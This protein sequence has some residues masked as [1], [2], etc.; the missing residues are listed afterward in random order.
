MFTTGVLCTVCGAHVYFWVNK[1]FNLLQFQMT[2]H[3]S[4]DL[5]GK[6]ET[7]LCEVLP[8]WGQVIPDDGQVLFKVRRDGCDIAALV[9]YRLYRWPGH[10][11][12]AV[13]LSGTQQ[14]V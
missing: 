8:R 4:A 13:S 7:E 12:T 11:K 1:N 6:L 9:S 2:E 3:V 14:Q 10:L 5:L